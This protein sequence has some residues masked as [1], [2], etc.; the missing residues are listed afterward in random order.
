MLSLGTRIREM[1]Q[2]KGMTQIDLAK[3]LCTPSMIS[4]IES[5]RARPSYKILFEISKKLDVTLDKLLVN[6]DLDLEY[7]STFKMAQTMIVAKEYRA[8]LPLLESVADHA[9]EG[10]IPQL[11]LLQALGTCQFHEG[12]FQA[13]ELNFQ[14]AFEIAMVEGHTE[15]AVTALLML[16]QIA[17]DKR[18]LSV[19]LHNWLHGL[20]ELRRTD[21]PDPALEVELMTRIASAHFDSGKIQDAVDLYE[22]LVNRFCDTGHIREMAELHRRLGDSYRRLEQ[23][24]KAIHHLEQS[25]TLYKTMRFQHSLLAVRRQHAILQGE[26]GQ[27]HEAM[28]VLEELADEYDREGDEVAEGTTLIALGKMAIDS[29]NYPLAQQVAQRAAE[30]LPENHSETG[31]LH[32]LFATLHFA[33][34]EHLQGIE[35]LRRA[36]SSYREHNRL[37]E[38]EQATQELC[39]SLATSQSFE[40][41]FKELLGTHSLILETLNTRGIVL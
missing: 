39:E 14:Q 32:R 29:F 3:E 4:Q 23:H 20:D 35:A 31:D 12:K 11:D 22:D 33:N 2:K 40:V 15:A 19:A 38:L 30:M 28:A 16:G 6:V 17:Y 10:N 21:S 34:D 9:G 41:A 18:N 27:L 13:S 1:R 8:A 7:L 36:I 24:S 25:I 26:R 37:H 5:D